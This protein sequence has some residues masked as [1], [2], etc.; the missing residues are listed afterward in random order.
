LPLPEQFLSA[1]PP[2]GTYTTLVTRAI[3]SASCPRI[4]HLQPL[5]KVSTAPA[6]EAASSRLVQFGI[7][8]IC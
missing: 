3:A 4:R 2:Q 8:L 6:L 7:G 5:A 1:Y